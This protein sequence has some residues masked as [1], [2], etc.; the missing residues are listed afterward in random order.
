MY[1]CTHT[2]THT[3]THT[4]A[5]QKENWV[6]RRLRRKIQWLQKEVNPW[7]K[8]ELKSSKAIAKLWKRSN[9]FGRGPEAE[10]GSGHKTKA[11][12]GKKMQFVVTQLPC[13]VWLFATP[14]TTVHQ[15][16]LSFTISLSLLKLMYTE[17]VM[18]SNHP[19]LCHPHLLLLNFPSIKVFSN[20]STL[21][22]RW[23]R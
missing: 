14:W 11:S 6:L 1:V 8:Y 22:M 15:A 21:R 19:V 12:S 9:V 5:G 17:L 13:H 2:W 18:P 3:H 4:L 16:S 23:P 20:E 10:P 7:G